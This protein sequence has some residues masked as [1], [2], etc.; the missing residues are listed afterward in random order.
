MEYN[1]EKFKESANKKASITWM[2]LSA[3]LTLSYGSDAA[4]GLYPMKWFYIFLAICW[5]PYLC[6]FFV[7]KIMGKGTS[8]YRT[9]VA[10]GYGLFYSY[11]LFTTTTPIAFIYILPLA[12]MLV[13]YKNRNFL[14]YYGIA[15]F[16]IIII[17]IYH[18]FNKPN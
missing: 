14:I 3:I 8:A 13:L 10:V 15:N 7:L 1:E 6:G 16:V 5:I 2:I 17:N 11:V 18:L 4:N 9:V 12:S